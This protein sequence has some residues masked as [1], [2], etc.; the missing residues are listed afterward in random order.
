MTGEFKDASESSAST[1]L[2]IWLSDVLASVVEFLKKKTLL[3]DDLW[4]SLISSSWWPCQL[5]RQDNHL[6]VHRFWKVTG[7]HLLLAKYNAAVASIGD[8]YHQYQFK[9]LCYL[10]MRTNKYE[11]GVCVLNRELL[12][13]NFLLYNTL[14]DVSY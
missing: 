13:Q 3:E 10:L 1:I 14:R 2:V 9:L 12:S 7:T 8:F 11:I 6:N 4:K 5:Y